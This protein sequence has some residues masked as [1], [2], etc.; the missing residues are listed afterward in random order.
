[1]IETVEHWQHELHQLHGQIA[2]RFRRA[3]PRHRALGY[4]RGLLS[5]CDRKNGWQLAERLGEATPDGVQRL[6]NAADWDAEAVR[7]DLRSYVV[8]HLSHRDA[9][10]IVDETGF[11]KKGT[12]SV[13]VKR[14]YSGTAGRIEN[15]QIGVFLC[16][17]SLHGA[18]FLDRALY[19]PKEWASDKARRQAAG[20]PEAVAFATKPRL[21]EAML[22]RAFAAEIPHAWVTGDT[23]YGGDRRL[24]LFLE[25][26]EQPFVLAVP[27]NERLWHGGPTYVAA[28]ELA[29]MA[30]AQAWQRLSAGAGSK[31][32]RLYDWRLVELWRLQL[33]PA[34]QA[35]GHY[36]LVRRSISDPEELAYY[37]VFARRKEVTLQRLVTVAGSRWQIEQAFEAAKG[38]CGL[39]EYEVRK[40]AAWHRH[41][42]LSL[43]AHA[44][45][46]VMRAHAQKKEVMS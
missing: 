13:G 18:A 29:A 36:L 2:P 37:V 46:V 17:A 10:L 42:I 7:D 15:C 24:R 33:T 32:A 23:V 12:H 3:E 20:V 25:A 27:S 19:L 11:L 26:H 41:I 44:F 4:L 45:L 5:P 31:G 34:E 14:Q 43:L 6:L 21:A 35:W 38:E 16:Y 30:D 1:M 40:W 22:E 9:V 28:E 8:D 39:D